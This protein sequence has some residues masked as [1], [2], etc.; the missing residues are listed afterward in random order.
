[1][2]LPIAHTFGCGCQISE[3]RFTIVCMK[4]LKKRRKVGDSIWGPEGI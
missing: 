2:G 4:H 3:G 1:M